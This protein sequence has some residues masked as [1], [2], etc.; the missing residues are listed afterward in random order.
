MS[1]RFGTVL[2]PLAIITAGVPVQ[3]AVAAPAAA[4]AIAPVA[5]FDKWSEG[6]ADDYMRLNP[7][8]TTASQYF[9]GAEQDQLDRLLAPVTQA[10]R[11]RQAALAREGLARLDVFLAGPLSATQR[12]SAET[13]RWT[14]SNELAGRPF[15]D[16]L[17]IFS[18]LGGPQVALPR[19][20]TQLH[21][22]RRAADV[23][24]YLA[25]LEL[26]P[27]RLDE[28]IAMARSAAARS[29]LPPRFIL[30][31]AQ[32]QVAAFLKPAAGD[33]V[34]VASLAERSAKIADLTPQA[35]SAAIARA[36]RIVDKGIRPAY[37]RVQ[38]MLAELHPRTG[39][40]A[41]ISRLPNGAAA[42][43]YLLARNAGT[44]LNAEQ[45][46]GIGL[47]EVARIEGEMDKYLRQ[48]GYAEGS[49]QQRMV[50]LDKSLQPA[51]TPDPRP[52][53][54]ARYAE[55]LRDAEQRS[56][57]LFNLKPRAPIE[58]RREPALTETTSSAHYT[59]PAPDGSRP[60]VFWMPLP[61]PEY[62][63]VVMRTLAYHE[64]VPGHHFQIALQQE[65]ADLPKYRAR[66]IFSGGS[67]NSEGWALYVEQLAMEQGWYEGDTVGMLGGLAEQL[68]RARRLVVDTGLHTKGWTRQQAI[69]YG[70][71]ASEVDRYV[72]N[73]GQ[74]CAYL[75][76][77]LRILELRE[78]ARS[79]LGERF[80]LPAFHDVV[81]RA[82]SVPMD[83]LAKIVGQWIAD[84]KAAA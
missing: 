8:Y 77:M 24:S 14:L 48:L 82:G 41:G 54:L 43:D 62:E 10:A 21:P 2:L 52:A 50:K 65:M 37:A 63:M 29:L 23:D 61:G 47:R 45:V 81:L 69:D 32:Q 59:P 78:Q 84:T 22:M 9:S 71:P 1:L 27:A 15:Q 39:N 74:A 30:E 83:V 60:G 44:S 68:F 5:A 46:H 73:P 58:V 34:L 53:M 40:E 4:P 42:Y 51:S 64:G 49:I 28:A 13:M 38:A 26:A 55:L 79:A 19:L 35:R 57:A 75:L 67:A 33:N 25:R 3:A 72:A 6:F 66:R 20:M 36:T 80:T 70:M 17:F 7:E 18:Q 11:D 16:H 56:A 31:K 76:G 12:A